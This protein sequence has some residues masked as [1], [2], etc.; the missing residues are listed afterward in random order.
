MKSK[1]PLKAYDE[2]PNSQSAWQNQQARS[3]RNANWCVVSVDWGENATG[4]PDQV[5]PLF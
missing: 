5:G 4:P 2:L 1:S 3:G